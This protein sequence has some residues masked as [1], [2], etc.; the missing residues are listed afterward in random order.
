MLVVVVSKRG[1][2][3]RIA[4]PVASSV[5]PSSSGQF[6][7]VVPPS[8]SSPPTVLMLKGCLTGRQGPATNAA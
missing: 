5:N 7:A 8:A 4:N 3:D 1:P 6:Q 2:L